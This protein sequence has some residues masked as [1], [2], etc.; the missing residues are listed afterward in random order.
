MHPRRSARAQLTWIA[1]TN[2]ISRA[3]VDEDLDVVGLANVAGRRVG[4]FSLGMAQRLGIATTLLGDP[5]VLLFD[6]PVNGLDPE[7]VHWIHG[8]LHRLAGEGRMTLVSSHLLSEMALT[9]QD[10][11]A[12]WRGR[13]IAQCGS[14]SS[15]TGPGTRPCA[16]AL[17]GARSCVRC[18][19]SGRPRSP[20]TAMP[21]SCPEWTP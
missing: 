19:N 5:A 17:R 11:V 18:C 20:T 10:L 14:A 8:L 9:A 6:E 7:G 4:G 3:R 1:A 13:S 16:C 12:I 2:G 21:S 15:S